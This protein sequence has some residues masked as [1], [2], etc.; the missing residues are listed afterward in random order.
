MLLQFSGLLFAA[1]FFL[2][3]PFTCLKSQ[4]I[5]SAV[6]EQ[7]RLERQHP[8]MGTLFRIILYTTDT[9]R[10]D[11]TVQ[12][13]FA[14]IDSL[15]SMMS[16]YRSTSELNRI[17]HPTLVGK[18][19]TI[20]TE[21]WEVLVFSCRLA[22][23]S[24]GAFDPTIGPLSKLWRRA[25]RQQTF[26]NIQRIK[27]ARRLV[28]Y[29]YIELM[30]GNGIL[31]KQQ[32][33]QLDLGGIA[34]GYAL[35]EAA[36]ILQRNGY[37]HYLIDGGGDLLLGKAPPNAHGWQIGNEGNSRNRLF[38]ETAITTSGDKYRYL[39]WKDKRYS[40]II[41]P[42]TGRGVTHRKAVMIVV[43]KGMVD[44][45]LASREEEL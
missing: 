12:L 6:Q 20:S 33:I 27:E 24:R 21:L 13:T 4:H 43:P 26:P 16:D 29:Q 10:A 39:V 8:A 40:H 45:A 14:R 37:Y 34:K 19:Q 42:R 25:F 5:I 22:R 30:P 18:R 3:T 28:N 44:E 11:S 36:A 1:L 41:D 32:G 31:L 35:D 2:F 9:V 17:C 7:Y 15:E 38:S 23:E